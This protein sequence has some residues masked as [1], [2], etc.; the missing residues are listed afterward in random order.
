MDFVKEQT[1]TY[2]YS[3]SYEKGLKSGRGVMRT[4][5]WEY[6]GSF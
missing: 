5:E 6:K 4:D 2:E 1:D 3:G